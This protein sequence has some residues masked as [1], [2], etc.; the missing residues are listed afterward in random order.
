VPHLTVERAGY[1]LGARVTGL[2]LTRDLDQATVEAIR[3]AILEHLVLVFPGQRI[4]QAALQRLAQYFGEIEAAS[5][6]N[7]DPDAPLVTLLTNRSVDGRAFNGY[8]TG[9]NWHSDHSYTTHPTLYSFLAAKQ[10][11]PVGGDTMF[12]NMYLGYESLSPAMRAIVDELEGLHERALPPSFRVAGNTEALRLAEERDRAASA[13]RLPI[14]HRVGL[15]HPETGRKALYLGA[16]VRRFAGMTEEE[17]MPIIDFLNQRA[18]LNEFVY[19]HR[20]SVDDVVMWDNRA[21][22]HIALSDYNR[23]E[24]TRTMLRCSVA[25]ARSGYEY[26]GEGAAR[27]A[28]GAGA[29]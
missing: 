16:R 15:V 25:G 23:Q 29:Q 11:P 8:Q 27:Q 13:G 18:V 19:R 6:E 26:D 5:K 28:V 24:D 3:T 10:I 22:M 7:I 20:W 9:A 14:A 2:D 4:D 1:A 12:A 21:T 17:S